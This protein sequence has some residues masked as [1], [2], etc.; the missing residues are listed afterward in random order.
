MAR[1]SSS[2]PASQAKS[3][4]KAKQGKASESGSMARG[5]WA[6]LGRGLWRWSLRGLVVSPIVV[7]LLWI[8]VHVF[9]G[10]GP[11]LAD[12]LRAIIG[13]E[14]VTALENEAYAV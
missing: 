3:K 10:L 11:L 9:P 14:A 5:R 12:T 2:P 8:A 4:G 6:R 13:K 7:L 1:P